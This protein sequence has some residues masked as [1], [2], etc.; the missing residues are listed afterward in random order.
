MT[1]R[2]QLEQAII[3]L[4]AQRA[5]LG[6]AIVEAALGPLREKLAQLVAAPLAEPQRK[7]VT[8]LFAQIV[9]LAALANTLDPEDLANLINALWQQLDTAIITHGG[10]IDKHIGDTVM[11]LWSAEQARED[12]PERA[13]TAALE[14]QNTL[15][16]F[17]AAHPALA[18]YSRIGIN[19]GPVLLDTVGSTREFTAMGDTVNLAARLEQTAPANSILI[20]QNTYDLVRGVF[21]ITSQPPLNVKGKAEPVQTYI[22]QRAKPRALQE[23][24]RGIE[25]PQ[26]RMILSFR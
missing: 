14:I 5:L 12:D 15:R 16:T 8:V 3:A 17:A 25:N 7:Y 4:D 18:L 23:N 10:L 26:T 20:A 13:V 2:E 9:G 1:E 22:V 11:A 24:T 21:E 19:T 6:D